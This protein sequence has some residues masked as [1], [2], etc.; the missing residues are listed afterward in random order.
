MDKSKTVELIGWYG[1]LAILAGFALV[2]IGTIEGRS[3][4]FQLLNLSGSVAL[5]AISLA[6][7]AYQPATLN[8]I[9][10]GISVATI[11]SLAVSR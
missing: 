9:M 3:Y 5:A 7:K 1:P 10:A 11:I 6:K 8:I 4:T 2:S